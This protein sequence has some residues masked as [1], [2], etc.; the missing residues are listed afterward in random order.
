MAGL[1]VAGGL[2][3]AAGIRNPKRRLE[4]SSSFAQS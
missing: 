1:L 3:S 2:I 4:R